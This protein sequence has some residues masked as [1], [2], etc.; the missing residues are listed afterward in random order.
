MVSPLPG[1]QMPKNSAVINRGDAPA[2][3]PMEPAV[4]CARQPREVDEFCESRGLVP[5]LK[6]VYSLVDQSFD[7]QGPVQ[8][9]REEDA[10]TGEQWIEIGVTVRGEAAQ[11]LDAYDRFTDRWLNS[12][13]AFVR[14]SFRL[15]YRLA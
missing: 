14:D 8:L 10:E 11:V 5:Y 15:A 1:D 4:D 13:P 9:A 2:T 6:T 3:A 7:V 12:V